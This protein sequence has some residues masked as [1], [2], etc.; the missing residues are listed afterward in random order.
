VIAAADEK[1]RALIHLPALGKV[2]LKGY[3][4]S[5]KNVLMVIL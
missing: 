1:V 2:C 4:L 5:L 3:S